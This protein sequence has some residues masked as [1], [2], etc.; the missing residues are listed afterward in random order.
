MLF[1]FP[2]LSPSL[3]SYEISEK[4]LIAPIVVAMIKRYSWQ[5]MTS[6]RENEYREQLDFHFFSVQISLTFCIRGVII[7]V[8]EPDAGAMAG[9]RPIIIG[10][11]SPPVRK[12]RSNRSK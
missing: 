12:S 11:H 10:K 4:I 8:L 3:L 2:V 5:T 7:L 9:R 6:E 1:R